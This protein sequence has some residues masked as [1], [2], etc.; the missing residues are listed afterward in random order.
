MQITTTTT[1][2]TATRDKK[3]NAP[4]SQSKFQN[5]ILFTP[6][7]QYDLQ[8]QQQQLLS[9]SS[10]CSLGWLPDTTHQLTIQID[11][12]VDRQMVS[13]L[14][15]LHPIG[16]H[17]FPSILAQTYNFQ[18]RQQQQHQISLLLGSHSPNHLIGLARIK[19]I[20]IIILCSM[21]FEMMC[22]SVLDFSNYF[23]TWKVRANLEFGIQNLESM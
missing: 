11:I 20:I 7:C 10:D 9:S 16:I 5:P 21:S 3:V 14:S 19:N 1:T 23:F 2:T 18:S 12:Q 8:Q 13:Q 22:D 17:F 15:L 6:A 4:P